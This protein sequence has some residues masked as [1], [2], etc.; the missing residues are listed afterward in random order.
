MSGPLPNKIYGSRVKREHILHILHWIREKC[1]YGWKPGAL[2]KVVFA[3][4]V[5]ELPLLN[6]TENPRKLWEVYAKEHPNPPKRNNPALPSE[7]VPMHTSPPKQRKTRKKKKA[8]P[9]K[10]SLVID[11]GIVAADAATV[12]ANIPSKDAQP[13]A[14]SFQAGRGTFSAYN[15]LCRAFEYKLPERVPRGHSFVC[16]EVLKTLPHLITTEGNMARK[17]WQPA[18]NL[19]APK[20]DFMPYHQE[21]HHTSSLA[22]MDVTKQSHIVVCKHSLHGLQGRAL[23]WFHD[24]VRCRNARI[25]CGTRRDVVSDIKNFRITMMG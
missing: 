14:E 1:T 16:E 24:S 4:K 12:A 20:R 2:K 15:D 19:I 18:T 23:L 25:A 17:K 11:V 3:G 6:R 8:A 13:W 9:S 7:Q 21:W 5:Y 22:P 10:Q